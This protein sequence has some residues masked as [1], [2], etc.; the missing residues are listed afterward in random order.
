M[1]T[2]LS[3][4]IFQEII[5]PF[6]LIFTLVFAILEKTNLLGKDKHQ[7]NAI[8]GFVIA[9]ILISFTKY[10]S[11]LQDF[12]IFLVI[13]LFIIFVALLLYGFIWGE[14]GGDM[15]AKAVGLKWTLGIAALVAVIWA[16]LYVTG[17]IDYVKANP[18]ILANVLF[19]IF[20]IAAIVVVL[21]TGKKK[22]E[23]KD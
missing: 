16:A 20:I 15:L 5:L 17:G 14:T 4:P 12:T 18:N 3:Y 21:N 19:I 10:V 13:G 11:W 1:A 22:D 7:I 9:A 8:I 2:F 6:I 23:K